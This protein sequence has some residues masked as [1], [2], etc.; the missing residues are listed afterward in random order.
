MQHISCYLITIIAV[1][2]LKLVHFAES[3]DQSYIVQRLKPYRT[4]SFTVSLCYSVG[5]VT[6]ALGEG[7]TLAAGKNVL[8]NT[9]KCTHVGNQYYRSAV[10]WASYMSSLFSAPSSDILDVVYLESFKQNQH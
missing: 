5:C 3:Q 2:A 6:S 1:F 9:K 8:T 10:L 7:Q 4:Y